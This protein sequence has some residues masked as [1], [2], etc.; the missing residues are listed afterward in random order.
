M[1]SPFS[2]NTKRAFLGAYQSFETNSGTNRNRYFQSQLQ[3]QTQSQLQTQSQTQSQLQTQTQSQL[4]T[5]TQSQ[6]Q[7]QSGAI[8]ICPQVP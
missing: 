6:T 1:K 3:T 5:Q 2:S 8:E 4:Q 7:S